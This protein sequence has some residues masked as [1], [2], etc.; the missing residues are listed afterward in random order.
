M[1]KQ[2]IKKLHRMIA[3]TLSLVGGLYSIAWAAPAATALP[4]GEQDMKNATVT[5]DTTTSPTNP[6]MTIEQTKGQNRAFISWDTFNIGKD[7][8]VN[9]K[10]YSGADLLVNAVRGNNMSEIAGK[11]N[12]TGNVALINPNGVIFMDGAQ[13][14]VGGL[15]VYAAGYDAASSKIINSGKEGSIEIQSGA[16]INV[17]VSAALANLSALNIAPSDYAIAIDSSGE[18]GYTNR[19][20]LVAEGNVEI[21]GGSTIKARDYTYVGDSASVGAEGFNVGVG[22][23]GMGGKIYI[24]SD[25]DADDYGSVIITHG[26]NSSKPVM[27]SVNGVS[28]Y[29][30]AAQ[31]DGDGDTTNGINAAVSRTESGDGA[32]TTYYTK[33]DYKNGPSYEIDGSSYTDGTSVSVEGPG[34]TADKLSSSSADNKIATSYAGNGATTIT[35]SL[36]VNNID[37]LQD[38]EDGTYGN[39][40][41][42]YVLGRDINATDD[43]HSYIDDGILYKMTDGKLTKWSPKDGV[44]ITGTKSGGDLSKTVNGTTIG[45]SKDENKATTTLKGGTTLSNSNGTVGAENKQWSTTKGVSTVTDKKAGSTYTI[46]SDTKS[47]VDKDGRTSNT[48]A[49]T[50]TDKDNTYT[51]DIGRN[52]VTHTSDNSVT[53]TESNTVTKAAGT[54]DAGYTAT[55]TDGTDTA[56]GTSGTI[57]IKDITYQVT[58][59]KVGDTVTYGGSSVNAGKNIV[60]AGGVTTAVT[61]NGTDGVKA[62]TIASDTVKVDGKTTTVI[63]GTTSYQITTG[64]DAVTY[65][66]GTTSASITGKKVTTGEVSADISAGKVVKG[67][68]T[69]VITGDTAGS[70]TYSGQDYAVADGAVSMIDSKTGKIVTVTGDEAENVL[71]IFSD[72]KTALSNAKSI[73][74]DYTTD[75]AKAQS[76]TKTLDGAIETLKEVTEKSTAEETVRSNFD[77]AAAQLKSDTA[78]FGAASTALSNAD[79]ALTQY[80]ALQKEISNNTKLEPALKQAYDEFQSSRLDDKTISNIHSD[81][82]DDGKGFNPIGSSDAPFTGKLDGFS[83]ETVFG[84]YNL[85]INRPDEDN[86]GLI[87]VAGS[88]G[89]AAALSDI[90]LYSTAITG[91]KNVGTVAGTLQQES[92][93]S[94]SGTA[95]TVNGTVSGTGESLGGLVGLVDG[96][97]IWD[98]SSSATVEGGNKAGG[99]AGMLQNGGTLTDVRNFGNVSGKEDVGGIA[100]Y[101]EGGT[102][103]GSGSAI[104]NYA[105][106]YNTGTV[107]GT[108]NTGGIVGHAK[109]IYMYGVFNTNEDTPLSTKS[110]LIIDGDNKVIQRGDGTTGDKDKTI[111]DPLL[112]SSYGKVTGVTN[113]GGLVG[114]L[115]DAPDFKKTVTNINISSTTAT[116][117]DGKTTK[118][119]VKDAPITN[120][121][122]DT[123]YNAGNITGTGDNTGGLVGSMTGGTLS[124]VYN[125]DNNT[126]L[127]EQGTIPDAV[128][129]A[130]ITDTSDHSKI[131]AYNSTAKVSDSNQ[132]LTQYYSFFT[133]DDSGSRTY[134]YFL[135][136]KTTSGTTQKG[137]GGIYV[138]ADGKAAESLPSTK[139]RYYFNRTFNKDAN[140]TGTGKNTGGLVGSMMTTSGTT[141]VKYSAGSVID[142]AYNAG[143]ITG[144]DTAATGALVG[145]KDA[146]SLI[147][148]SFYVTGKDV[149]NGKVY[150]NVDQAVGKSST[151]T[152]KITN[153]AA[154]DAVES[155]KKYYV[156]HDSTRTNFPGVQQKTDTDK[157]SST[158]YYE[159]TSGTNGS[160]YTDGTGSI[161][162]IKEIYP[163]KTEET[164][165][166]ATGKTTYTSSRSKTAAYTKVDGTSTFTDTN[167]NTYTATYD[168]ATRQIVLTPVSGSSST[169]ATVVLNAVL[170]ARTANETWTI[171]EDQTRP[172]LTAFL[173]K[174]S[175]SRSFSYDGTTHNLKTDDVANL[176]GRADFDG[177]AGKDVQLSNY[178]LS[179]NGVSSEYTYDNTSIWSPQHGYFMDPEST[180]VINPVNMSANLY[181]TRVYGDIFNTRGYYV[182][183]PYTATDGTK[184]YSFY[185]PTDE[186][187]K[188]DKEGYTLLKDTDSDKALTKFFGKYEQTEDGLLKLAEEKGFYVLEL[189][190]FINGEGVNNLGNLITGLV[191][192]LSNSSSTTTTSG[193]NLQHLFSSVTADTYLDAGIY[194]VTN[195]QITGLTATNQN[196]T[197]NYGGQLTVKQAELYYTY[198]G[199]REYGAQNKDGEHTYTLVGVDSKTADSSGKYTS[200]HGFLKSWNLTDK[201]ITIKNDDGTETTIANPYGNFFKQNGDT[202]EIN[203]DNIGV[204]GYTAEKTTTTTDVTTGKS[205]TETS[206]DDTKSASL[207]DIY[208]NMTGTVNQDSIN[209]PGE[210]STTTSKAIGSYGDG[211]VSDDMYT[212]VLVDK[213]GNPLGYKVTSFASTNKDAGGTI[214]LYFK[215]SSDTTNAADKNIQAAVNKFNQNYKLVWKEGGTYD[216]EYTIGNPTSSAGTTAD[217]AGIKTTARGL[218]VNDSTFTITPKTATVTITGHRAYGDTMDTSSYTTSTGAAASGQDT[219]ANQYNLNI[220]GLTNGDS[221]SVLD[222]TKTET[223]LSGIDNTSGTAADAK[224]GTEINKYTNVLRDGTTKEA[225]YQNINDFEKS[226]VSVVN[227]EVKNGTATDQMKVTSTTTG[228]GT[229]ATISY[230]NPDSI[231][232]SNNY[233]YILQDGTHQLKITPVDIHVTVSGGK[234]YGD[235]T[236]QAATD[237]T[238]SVSS[239]SGG[240][241]YD[242]QKTGQVKLKTGEVADIVIANHLDEK[243]NAGTYTYDS[244]NSTDGSTAFTISL[245]DDTANTDRNDYHADNYNISFDTTYTISPAELWYTYEGTRAYGAGNTTTKNTF[246]LV[247]VDGTDSNERVRGFL[248]SWDADKYG[249]GSDKVISLTTVGDDKNALYT[250]TGMAD[251]AANKKDD[252]IR[253]I[254]GGNSDNTYSHVIVDSTGK[255]IGYNLSS[256]GLASDDKLNLKD[257]TQEQKDTFK[258]NYELVWK[259][260]VTGNTGESG[261]LATTQSAEVSKHTV[262]GKGTT[263]ATKDVAIDPSTLTINPV[264]LTVEVTGKREYGHTMGTKDNVKYDVSNGADRT[265]VAADGK[266]TVNTAGLTNETYNINLDGLKNDDGKA[267]LDDTAVKN[268]LGGI[269]AGD[270]NDADKISRYTSVKQSGALATDISYQEEKVYAYDLT[271]KS[272]NS[273][274]TGSQITVTGKTGTE[275]NH[276]DLLAAGNYDYTLQDGT[277]TLTIDRHDLN[278]NITAERQY[279]D[280]SNQRVVSDYKNNAIASGTMS[281]YATGITVDGENG[282]QNGETI[283]FTGSKVDLSQD[284]YKADVGEYK[285][286]WYNDDTGN[287][288]AGITNIHLQPGTGSGFDAKNY[289]I[290]YTTTYK[291]DKADLY[292]TYDGERNYGQDNS[293]A[294]HTYTIVGKDRDSQSES[295]RGYLKSWDSGVL[296][297]GHVLNKDLLTVTNEGSGAY[298]MTGVAVQEG[299]TSAEKAKNVT[300]PETSKSIG[301]D[302]GYSHVIV[303]KDGK[304]LSY[305]LDTFGTKLAGKDASG[306]LAKNYNLVWKQGGSS[307]QLDKAYTASNTASTIDGNGALQAATDTANKIAVKNSS[308]KID[309]LALTITVTGQR[310]YGDSMTTNYKTDGSA[311]KGTYNI[312]LT[313]SFANDEKAGSILNKA[314]VE[315]MLQSLEN[316]ATGDDPATRENSNG[317]TGKISRYTD[318]KRKADNPSQ[319]DSYS[320]N[321]GSADTSSTITLASDVQKDASGNVISI[322][323]A[324]QADSSHGFNVLNDN[325][326]DYVV[327]EGSHTLTINPVNLTVNVKG[328][329]TYGKTDT[330]YTVTSIGAKNRETIV[331]GSG[332]LSKLEANAAAG[333]YTAAAWTDTTGAATST[334]A[335]SGKYLN[336][337]A[338]RAGQSSDA[339][340]DTDNGIYQV[341]LAAGANTDGSGLS[342]FSANNYNITYQTTQ[343]V[344][345]AKL[346]ITIDGTKVYGSQ[347]TGLTAGNMTITSGELAHGDSLKGLTV[348][349]NMDQHTDAGTYRHNWSIY[350]GGSVPAESYTYTDV[351]GQTHTGDSTTKSWVTG[352][353]VSAGN[354]TFDFNNY[355]V[356][357]RSTYE[358]TKRPLQ[359]DVT[360]TSVYGDTK[361]GYTYTAQA[362]KPEG[363]VEEG[364]VS[365]QQFNPTDIKASNDIDEK[366]DAGTYTHTS[367]GTSYSDAGNQP[368][369]TTYKGITAVAADSLKDAGDTGF[370][371][372]NYAITLHQGTHTVEKRTVRA[373]VSGSQVYGESAPTSGD[374]Y[375]VAFDMAGGK[376]VKAHEGLVGGQTITNSQVTVQNSVG[377]TNDV[378]TYTTTQS[379]V[380]APIAYGNNPERVEGKD[381][382]IDGLI[383]SDG[384]GTNAFKNNNYNIVLEKGSYTVNQRPVTF[385][386]TGSRTY[387]EENSTVKDY[388]IQQLNNVDTAGEGLTGSD[389]GKVTVD[390]AAVSNKTEASTDAGSYGTESDSS[391]QVLDIDSSVRTILG[392]DYKN[393]AITYQDQFTINPRTVR[394]TIAGESTYGDKALT[395]GTDY[396]TIDFEKAGADGVAAKE[397]LV[398]G[399]TIS[400][401]QVT[402][403]TAG[404]GAKTDAGTYHLLQEGGQPG[405]RGI[406]VTDDHGFKNNNYRIVMD[407][408]ST[409][410]IDK[411]PLTITIRGE[412]TYGDSTSFSGR[413]YAVTQSGLQ[414]QETIDF[415]DARVLH[416]QETADPFSEAGQYSSR[417]GKGI[418]GFDS[419]TLQG[420]GFKLGNYALTYDTDFVIHKRPVDVYM[421]S[422]RTSG[423]PS[424]LRMDEP[425]TMRN[426][427]KEHQSRFLSD[428]EVID[429]SPQIIAA[430]DYPGFDG[431]GYLDLYFAGDIYRNY[432]I[433]RHTVYHIL[434]DRMVKL[435]IYNAVQPVRRPILDVMYFKVNGSEGINRWGGTENLPYGGEIILNKDVTSSIPAKPKIT[436]KSDFPQV[437]GQEFLKEEITQ[438]VPVVYTDGRKQDVRGRYYLAYENDNVAMYPA[439]D[440]VSAPLPKEASVSRENRKLMRIPWQGGEGEYHVAYA[441]G[442]VQIYPENE[443]AYRLV[444]A[445]GKDEQLLLERSLTS[446]VRELGVQLEG[447]DA[448]YIYTK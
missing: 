341:Q 57:A 299:T 183:V 169:A 127:R 442:I 150:S 400:K 346:T 217:D 443:T 289:D 154:L 392:D 222:T 368:K 148:D 363:G 328:E 274:K 399:Q 180:L 118:E 265:S 276:Y 98:S 323:H 108:T 358:V 88:S 410:T 188:G 25:R 186:S 228:E 242:G 429:T 290:H 134:Y 296:S 79:T 138:T 100:G 54:S 361:A 369:E 185:Q 39:L 96:S 200:T 212:H 434:P 89:H 141:A 417:D 145:S 167:G 204:T 230:D 219:E 62:G 161:D 18:D 292:Y 281:S 90:H 156:S 140:V 419:D 36:L 291:V 26:E 65:T 46:Q 287:G 33:H 82:W 198:D 35:T 27:Q 359:L 447:I 332:T 326:Y 81:K 378:G 155:K 44:A 325:N 229:S 366:A 374:A 421:E 295:V 208:A 239:V 117:A 152:S 87:S 49:K 104:Y 254:T 255:I 261:K 258:K 405:I 238:A 250:M 427:P 251:A 437:S 63:D 347:P 416:S 425:M 147:N 130:S 388:A 315:N 78:L 329:S 263:V 110:Q 301:K 406:T 70:V 311:G 260:Q 91:N 293:A 412:K 438:A 216:K 408:D 72:A 74:S 272:G 160:F 245:E 362:L 176:Y 379:D 387:G 124:N 355:D 51:A 365:G 7:A 158:I 340:T 22:A 424:S 414:N 48:A 144:S 370:K 68:T 175:L 189:N 264:N 151:D 28:I 13:V 8:T 194:N 61:K 149:T 50:V 41:G 430:G 6:V 384:T 16:V 367:T 215:T 232:T 209:K 277:H 319:I 330:T 125:A 206:K 203:Q 103:T 4:T 336:T 211:A 177:D 372:S 126:V 324:N 29:T 270:S 181:G 77:K 94:W 137:A 24:R 233:D 55:I 240:V 207:D 73:Y 76:L 45:Y 235:F 262:D 136:V 143:T 381:Q 317:K 268:L 342:T 210:D 19:I 66:K 284:F 84:L 253:N 223:L 286:D 234:T 288:T 415:G 321:V 275:A 80:N 227:D 214:Q 403:Q 64:T 1:K 395:A 440:A 298:T 14:N 338:L 139:E 40:D 364:L 333:S 213:E 153:T 128:R 102:I 352:V 389:F 266:S 371:S 402:V 5:R 344:H 247:G 390:T 383:V 353:G 197:I 85:T 178:Q 120:N 179:S 201:T 335:A 129:N 331:A 256:L 283:D 241:T 111:T 224:S 2:D 34:V 420:E 221:A 121:V 75:A 193:S 246:K 146:D 376:D 423:S 184:H 409:Y 348:D 345:P 248:K 20:H 448:I 106:T 31:V 109:G 300:D 192:T 313:G 382:G 385:L 252:T 231:L 119:A 411:R 354:K 52:T 11:L 312:A 422:R 237:Y 3:L 157:D 159:Y 445:K 168:T 380:G 302:S 339:G 205:T 93:L 182:C 9:V 431:R 202:Y 131:Y 171:Y 115:N 309:P 279:G 236:S 305:T 116:N 267:I 334:A 243:S 375:Q 322:K 282:L 199:S 135:P 122:I 164:K 303:D 47:V 162:S 386:T 190:G 32:T 280:I 244:S 56:A 170:A 297:G 377:E 226:K 71:N 446:A 350:A 17:G 220:D 285:H 327:S 428:M 393:Y 391:E 320:L 67:D 58:D 59:G 163:I 349:D 97:S 21:E 53:N 314:N 306:T 69:A 418:L 426:V 398:G 101:V 174:A 436:G 404:I 60:T 310:D 373:T 259:P 307:H 86:V 83:G 413:D 187:S 351:D 308:F 396:K 271:K 257:A 356:D 225:V 30:N 435:S 191:T 394:V 166:S 165:N 407:D 249:V 316:H 132:D 196:Y 42:R 273:D 360:S 114:Y 401:S 37:Q 294:M 397:G 112:K 107:T 92:S 432:D 218:T 38:I 123:S 133:V 95:G 337:A 12:A 15:G 142:S 195:A 357:F 444:Q 105:N 10:Q 439:E 99:I 304:I 441:D 269:D 172:L 318:V 43:V 173:N 278:L 343:V 113:T 23:V 433:H